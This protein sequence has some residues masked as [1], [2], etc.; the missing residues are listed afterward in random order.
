MPGTASV[1]QAEGA[2]G[3]PGGL[4]GAD[5][6]G[7][8]AA[9]PWAAVGVEAEGGGQGASPELR[10]QHPS[11]SCVLVAG[12]GFE[13][14]LGKKPHLTPRQERRIRWICVHRLQGAT[15]RGAKAHTH[16]LCWGGCGG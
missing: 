2:G 12:A 11:R 4:C 3:S 14:V 1:V 7:A 9:P 10:T 5:V 13:A 15:G 8:E 16:V 6:L